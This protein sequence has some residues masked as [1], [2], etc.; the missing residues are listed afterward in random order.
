MHESN[1]VAL[2]R[3][4][5]NIPSNLIEDVLSNAPFLDSHVLE[6]VTNSY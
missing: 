2:S 6:P 3:S 4:T 5:G 1:V